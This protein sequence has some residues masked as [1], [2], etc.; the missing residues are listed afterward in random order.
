MQKRSSKFVSI[1]NQEKR[2]AYFTDT[3]EAF[4]GVWLLERKEA[5]SNQKGGTMSYSV[6]HILSSICERRNPLFLKLSAARVL[7]AVIFSCADNH[8]PDE[9]FASLI[10]CLDLLEKDTAKL[11]LELLEREEAVV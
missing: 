1:S 8:E 7:Q 2:I 6:L 4:G 5:I 11:S 10:C 9:V 3:L